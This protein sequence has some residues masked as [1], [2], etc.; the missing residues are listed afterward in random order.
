MNLRKTIA[1]GVALALCAGVAFA[2]DPDPRVKK[3][4]DSAKI[5]Y[6]TNDS[7]NYIVSFT[8][9]NNPERSHGVF[10]VSATE[11]YK[12]TEIREIWSVAAIL[13]GYPDEY[14]IYD[15]LQT[16]STIKIGAWAM[17]ET[18]EGEVWVIYT[19]KVPANLSSKDLVNFIY[20]VAEICDEW[21]EEYVGEDIY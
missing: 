9:E 11:N 4:L 19:V 15:M 13:P 10:V 14:T 12:G 1:L 18:D 3:L 21:E 6:S 8:M 16:N 17:E 5:K 7:G 2:Q 20:F